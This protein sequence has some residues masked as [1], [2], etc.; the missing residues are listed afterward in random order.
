M[1]KKYTPD[2]FLS[3]SEDWTA[4]LRSGEDSEIIRERLLQHVNKRHFITYSEKETGMHDLDLVIILKGLRRGVARDIIPWR[5]L[6][7]SAAE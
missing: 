1:N 2:Y 5:G 3:I 4:I 7:G 6:A